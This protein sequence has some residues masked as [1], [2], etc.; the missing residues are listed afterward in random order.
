MRVDRVVLISGCSTGIGRDLARRLSEEGYTVV[1][2][3]RR[4]ETLEGLGCR[5]TLPLDVTRGD[6]V[7]EA[8]SQTLARLGRIDVLVNNAGY[9]LRS[10]IEDLA[11]AEM[12]KLFQTN[13]FGPLRLIKAV[14]PTMRRQ[15]GGLIVNIG[16][17]SGKLAFAANGPY[18]A[19]KFALEGLS[20]ALRQELGPLGIDVVLVEPGP[21][22]T[23]FARTSERRSPSIQAGGAYTELYRS[24]DSLA[25]SMRRGEGGP[26]IV[27]ERVLEAL[28]ARR[29]KT[30]YLALG[31]GGLGFR[32]LLGLPDRVRDRLVEALRTGAARRG[33]QA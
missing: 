30:R 29:P 15:G 22:A 33:T 12:L 25:A 31:G 32:L 6:S 13:V 24:C 7:E 21:V 27:T 4:V 19:T 18:S 10:S 16:S 20:D 23:D 17:I 9:G 28:A 2:T 5:L 11:E 26:S 1:A 3:A 14:L 8:I